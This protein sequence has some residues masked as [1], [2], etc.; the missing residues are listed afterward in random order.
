MDA[1]ELRTHIDTALNAYHEDI[2]RFV[3]K[4]YLWQKLDIACRQVK[5][6]L[7]RPVTEQ[8]LTMTINQRGLNLPNDFMQF[9]DEHLPRIIE[10]GDDATAEGHVFPIRSDEEMIE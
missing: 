5:G 3:S 6:D 9:T 4:A 7:L 10:S 8:D 2:E 1:K